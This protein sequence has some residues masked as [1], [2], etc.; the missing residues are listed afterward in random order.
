MPSLREIPHTIKFSC[1]DKEVGYYADVEYDCQ[2]YHVCREDRQ[3]V[4]FLCPNGTI[5]NQRILACDWWFDVQCVTITTQYHVNSQGIQSQKH[6]QH[7]PQLIDVNYID[8]RGSERDTYISHI[9]LSPIL[10]TKC[11]NKTSF[12]YINAVTCG[13][14]RF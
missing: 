9:R 10:I 11:R 7:Q 1:G 4:T 12:S 3:R 6:P 2:V 8:L 13:L 14:A 5:F